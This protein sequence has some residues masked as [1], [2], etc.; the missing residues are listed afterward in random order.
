M[1]AH[2]SSAS[3]HIRSQKTQ[4]TQIKSSS[5]QELAAKR[6]LLGL[7]IVSAVS[8]GLTLAPWQLLRVRAAASQYV[9]HVSVDGLN[10]S[11]MA[12]YMSEG[13]LPNLA[14]LQNE[15]SWTQNAR[16]DYDYTVTLPN[17]VDQLTGRPVA[18]KF[19]QSGTGH[20]WTSNDVPPL[21]VNLHTNRGFYV[22]SAFD[23]AHDNGLSTALY[24]T[25]DKF[26][27]FENSYNAANGAPDTI[28]TDNGTDKIDTYVNYDLN[29]DA[30]M[31]ALLSELAS[32]PKQYTFVH[33]HDADSA[34]HASGWGSTSYRDALIAVDAHLGSILNAISANGTLNNN[35]TIILTAD[36]GG[37]D[38]GHGDA[39]QFANFSIPF[40][41][42]GP[43]V[44]ANANLYTVNG[45]ATANPGTSRIDFG[46]GTPPIFNADAANCAL[47]RLGLSPIPGSLADHMTVACGDGTP[48]P[49]TST[50][51]STPTSTPTSAPGSPVTLIAPGSVWKYLDNGTDQGTAWQAPLFNDA[52]WASGAAPLGYGDPMATTINGGPV[53][54]RFI[55]S[56]FR[57]NFNVDDA[58]AVT[59]LTVN[60]RR[61]DG[62]IVYINGV[63]VARSNM[64]A[65]SVNYLSL[66][67]SGV[68]DADETTFFPFSVPANVLT[69][70]NN[71]IAVE[72]HQVN[73]TS[74]DVGFDLELIAQVSGIPATATSTPT[75][76]PTQPPVS[77]GSL[78][79]SV[80]VPSAGNINVTTQGS[81][82]WIVW[83]RTDA[84]SIDRKAT[85]G[86]TLST[87]SMIGGNS[88]QHNSPLL[89]NT[90]W[91]DGTPLPNG[92]STFNTRVRGTGNGFRITAPADTVTRTLRVHVGIWLARG[93]LQ[94]YLSDNS[95]TQFIDT[96]VQ[97][98]IGGLYEDIR[99]Y[100]FVYN[101]ASAN[102]TL[103]VEWTMETDFGGGDVSISAAALEGPVAN[104]PTPSPSAT[105]TSTPTPTPAPG[106][107]VTL[108]NSGSVWKY[109]DNGTDQG[110]AWQSPIFDDAAWASGA[111]PLGYGDPMATTINSGPANNVFVTSYFRRT[112]T[113]ADASAITSLTVRL[114]RD[115]GAVVYLNGAEIARSNM[116][117]GAVNYLTLASTGVG[118]ADETSFFS[119]NVPVGALSS[120]VNTVA[121]EVHQVLTNSSDL[122]F[123][124]ELVATSLSTGTATP[125]PTA[126]STPTP[127]G[128]QTAIVAAG[129][130]WKYLDNGTD[131]GTAWQS[132]VFDDAAWASGAAPLGYGD[133]MSTTINSGP[134]NNVFIT[135]YF[136]RSFTVNDPQAYAGL[137]LRLRRDDGAVVYL[138]GAEVA[139]SNMPTGAVTYLTL[140][141]TGIGG[142][143][144]TAWN[145]VGVP[146]N[147][148][149]QGTNT[150]AVEI[151]QINSTSS[152]LGFDLELVATLAAATPT[153]TQTATATSTATP[154]PTQTATAT[155][156]ATPTPTQTATATSTATPTPT[157][158]P[159]ATATAAIFA[160]TSSADAHVRAGIYANS[161]YGLSSQLDVKTES[162]TSNVR[163]AYLRFDTSS[164]TGTVT[165]AKVRLF[166]RLNQS[167]TLSVQLFSVSN[168]TWSETAITWN[169]KPALGATALGSI[170]VSSTSNTWYE[171]DVTTYVQAERAAGRNV[172]AFALRVPANDT[173]IFSVQ[174]RQASASNR[175]QLRLVR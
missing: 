115:D 4:I 31:S 170:S 33:F 97:E 100:T 101:A 8:L 79:G 40:I 111:A 112:F 142:T 82:D 91:S 119:Y 32:A 17:H 154:T 74:S 1:T 26:V 113:L 9:I 102:Q 19:G 106:T 163:W 130:A 61:D 86:N 88:A 122:G 63:E 78:I 27:L 103:T 89:N 137:T 57:R 175:P 48:P 125:T 37:V 76:T 22:S 139:R 141:S 114:R 14:R 160:L 83:G 118:D 56:Y 3:P 123:D 68:G 65:G 90:E 104:T 129:S 149:A 18:N 124:M 126:T 168:T 60:L 47:R 45:S 24:A 16:T 12:Q 150:I 28:G 110:T 153:P 21:G 138:N 164:V 5:K 108:I 62:A 49:P 59:G 93:R 158:T 66:A 10:P 94:A 30:M 53:D 174:S 128:G 64:P 152:D 169:N 133:P 50:P 95:A 85:G 127:S 132:P 73:N 146:S 41:L 42:W 144:E 35:T 70:G 2:H 46:A 162:T 135:S 155:S 23:V 136:R 167:G 25:K 29:S 80:A 121:V 140:A 15:G 87:W 38:F 20:V 117:A 116:P 159:T 99:T 84:L 44:S 75:A 51:E 105:S 13:V 55:T 151:H 172:V 166:G 34:G 134:A 69:T 67:S 107:P 96:S 36:H 173:E 72:V 43:A 11:W 92:T 52:A 71:T 145:V 131:Q 120:G 161:N 58:T 77:G 143:D 148:L 171:L 165:N 54:N 157:R 7:V 6:W 109:L 147:L 39:G 156:T 81:Q 98:T